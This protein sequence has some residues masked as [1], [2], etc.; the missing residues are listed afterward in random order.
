MINAIKSDLRK[1]FFSI[2]FLLS[3]IVF[4][5]LIFST[6]CV[7]LD[8]S[9]PSYSIAEFIFKTDKSLWLEYSSYSCISI[10]SQGFANQWIGIFIPFLAAFSC[11]PVFCDEYNSNYWRHI[12][13]RTGFR[14]YICSKFICSIIISVSLI[15][16]C[17]LIFAVVCFS[18]FPFPN[19]YADSVYTADWF[20]YYGF[21]RIFGSD[22]VLLFIFGRILTSGLIAQIGGLFCLAVSSVTMS[23]YVSLGIPVLTYF[24]FAQVAKPYMYSG[25]MED[26]KFYFLDNSARFSSVVNWFSDYT[27]LSLAFAYIYFLL[28]IAVFFVLYYYVMKRRLKQ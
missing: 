13:E 20:N 27:G 28:V 12:A 8:T 5:I 21:N 15:S 18:I 19:E 4:I 17:Y 9:T 26:A 3:I 14:K 10:F 7:L 6:G 23:K 16:I 2:N 24:F 11:V 25:K 22:S 1:S